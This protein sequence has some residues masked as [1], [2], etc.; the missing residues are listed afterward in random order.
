[1]ADDRATSAKNPDGWPLERALRAQVDAG[2]LAL[3]TA[4]RAFITH[5]ETCRPCRETSVDCDEAA[6]LRQ[7]YRAAKAATP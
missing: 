6:G 7:A 4:Y 1:M 5:T 2:Q 3:L